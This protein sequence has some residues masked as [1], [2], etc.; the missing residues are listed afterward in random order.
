MN[1][2]ERQWEDVKG[3]YLR[4]IEQELATVRGPGKRQVLEDVEEH[5][6]RRYSELNLSERT[7]EHLEEI[8]RDMGPPEEY[9]ELM[10]QSVS[11][12][13]TPDREQSGKIV[14]F[15]RCLT[16]LF[17]LALFFICMYLLAS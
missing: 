2:V 13:Q 15:D 1:G 17:F 6:E 11:E 8:I 14:A 5:L 7:P 16:V 12:K 3:R 4:Q 9:A 10:E